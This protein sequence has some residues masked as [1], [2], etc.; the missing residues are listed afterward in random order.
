MAAL[1][2]LAPMA[3]YATPVSS[4]ATVAKVVKK[5]SAAKKSSSAQAACAGFTI[6]DFGYRAGVKELVGFVGA[7]MSVSF[8]FSKDGK[9]LKAT[10]DGRA[11]S[12]K[13]KKAEIGAVANFCV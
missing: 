2:A 13:L 10:Y 1:I 8:T 4:D 3:T 6:A 5:K 12:G 11:G 9:L 7:G